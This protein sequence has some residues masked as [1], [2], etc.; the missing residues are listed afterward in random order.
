MHAGFVLLPGEPGHQNC[1]ITVARR[2]EDA[3]HHITFIGLAD[4]EEALRAKGFD[5]VALAADTHPAGTMD[6]WKQ[7][8]RRRFPL[9]AIIDN[10]KQYSRMIDEIVKDLDSI[11]Q[12]GIDVL[13]CDGLNPL[14]GL[15]ASRIGL[16]YVFLHTTLPTNNRTLP[17]FWSHAT[18][19]PDGSLSLRAR[20]AWHKPKLAFIHPARL[21]TFIMSR[22]LRLSGPALVRR[23]NPALVDFKNP[24]DVLDLTL[25][26]S[27]CPRAF[28]FPHPPQDHVEYIDALVDVDRNQEP[29]DWPDDDRPIVFAAMG[30]QTWAL[31][32]PERVFQTFVDAFRE[33]P[34]VRLILAVSRRFDPERLNDLP[35]NVTAH[36]FVPQLAVLERAS[37]FITHAGLNSVKE[38]ILCGVPMV[39][40]PVG[41]DQPSN[42]ARIAYHGLGLKGDYR[43]LT[44][45]Q[46][47]DQ[48]KTIL[49]DPSYRERVHQMK[50]HFEAAAQR[51]EVVPWIEKVARGE[52]DIRTHKR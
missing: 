21:L 32:R 5:Y 8:A 48:V 11:H 13:V 51:N 16:P 7:D 23:V 9:F 29:F 3:G 34:D 47:R 20:L 22:A 28:D 1:A 52:T 19:R 30:T 12:L 31:K 27:A 33:L 14:A 49:D 44:A 42:A 25:N 39:A 37:L 40:L 43:R 46:L 26:L 45:E 2:L 15:F 4:D 50:E 35:E 17:P 10:A 38:S 36:A 41:R 18:P 6:K 24:S